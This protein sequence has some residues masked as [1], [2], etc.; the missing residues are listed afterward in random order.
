MYNRLPIGVLYYFVQGAVVVYT[1]RRCIHDYVVSFL[2]SGSIFI[3]S[4]K[5][6]HSAALLG[7]ISFDLLQRSLF[8]LEKTKQNL[9]HLPGCCFECLCVVCQFV[10]YTAWVLI[11]WL[12]KLSY[13]TFGLHECSVIKSRN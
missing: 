12:P 10:M 13:T 3:G 4:L 6:Y 7:G 11:S 9:L 5:G 8:E 2:M 1:S